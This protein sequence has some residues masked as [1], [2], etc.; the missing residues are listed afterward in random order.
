[1]PDRVRKASGDHL[2]LDVQ[3]VLVVDLE[4][5]GDEASADG[6]CLAGFTIDNDLHRVPP[7]AD[8]RYVHFSA[9]HQAVR[10]E[11]PTVSPVGGYFHLGFGGVGGHL[12]GPALWPGCGSFGVRLLSQEG[13]RVRAGGF[14]HLGEL[15]GLYDDN[16]PSCDNAPPGTRK[17]STVRTRTLLDTATLLP[18][19]DNPPGHGTTQL[20]HPERATPLWHCWRASAAVMTLLGLPG[21]PRPAVVGKPGA[22]AP[23][24]APASSH[25]TLGL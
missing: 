12:R 1:M 15:T 19:R 23:R 6:V 22:G 4:D 17:P 20:A 11:Q 14:S 2:E 10:S 13:F 25:G 5:L 9:G 3:H 8:A 7:F 21:R 24:A 18:E 16:P